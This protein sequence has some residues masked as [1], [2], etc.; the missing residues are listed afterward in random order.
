MIGFGSNRSAVVRTPAREE[1]RGISEL[2]LISEPFA[3]RKTIAQIADAQVDR[4]DELR[5]ALEGATDVGTLL[6]L[7][8]RFH[9]LLIDDI[10]SPRLSAVIVGLH[11]AAAIHLA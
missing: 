11:K 9:S 10:A 4:A 7:S 6:A 3:V 5:Q 2:R 1:A 8:S